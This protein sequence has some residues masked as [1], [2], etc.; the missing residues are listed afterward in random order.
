MCLLNAVILLSAPS[1]KGVFFPSNYYELIR[2]PSDRRS[3]RF[4]LSITT[5]F[6]RESSRISQVPA[7]TL[8]TCHGLIT[9]LGR[10]NL[11]THKKDRFLLIRLLCIGLRW[12][13]KP[14]HL[15]FASFGAIPALQGHGSP[16]GLYVSLSTLHID[17]S[18]VSPYTQI[19]LI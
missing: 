11:A 6:L 10:H 2:L 17:C 16:Y 18:S 1:L 13:Y 7:E 5:R 19:F 4:L 12:R 8:H 15:G 9:P 3:P 14:R